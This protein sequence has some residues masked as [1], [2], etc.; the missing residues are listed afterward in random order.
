MNALRKV[1]REK[2]VE[3]EVEVP[4]ELSFRGDESDLMEMLGNLLDNACKYGDGQVRVAARYE[5]GALWVS[6]ADNG[7][8]IPADE[9]SRILQRGTRAD[10]GEPGQGIGLAVVREIAQGYGGELRISGQSGGGA[11]FELRL[12]HALESRRGRT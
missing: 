11:R 1:Y 7:P 3:F 12:P 5:A 4:E 10:L 6:V 8:G 9:R 2:A